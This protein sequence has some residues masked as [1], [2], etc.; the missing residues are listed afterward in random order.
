MRYTTKQIVMIPLISAYCRS[1]EDKSKFRNT[2]SLQKNC[3]EILK[4]IITHSSN[5][6]K[7]GAVVW[8]NVYPNPYFLLT[9]KVAKSENYWKYVTSFSSLMLVS[10]ER[11]INLFTNSHKNE[12][13]HPTF[14]YKTSNKSNE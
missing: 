2:Y 11:K 9:F 6:T 10:F 3:N 1:A 4:R 8:C 14:I 13:S 7:C 5:F 12:S